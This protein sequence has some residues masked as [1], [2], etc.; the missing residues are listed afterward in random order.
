[1]SRGSPGHMTSCSGKVIEG[2]KGR[3]SATLL[4]I[5]QGLKCLVSV[6][7]RYKFRALCIGELLYKF[8]TNVCYTKLVL[9]SKNCYAFLPNISDPV[10]LHTNAWYGAMTSAS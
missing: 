2:K 10:D 4:F 8:H 3:G 9:W 6:K 7:M 1:M 5:D